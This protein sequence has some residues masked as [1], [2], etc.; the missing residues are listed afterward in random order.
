MPA[1]CEWKRVCICKERERDRE[2]ERERERERA[3]ERE[4]ESEGGREGGREG[5]REAGAHRS[6]CVEWR[7]RWFG[8][9]SL[10]QKF[11]P[12]GSSGNISKTIITILNMGTLYTRHDGKRLN[13]WELTWEPLRANVA[14]RMSMIMGCAGASCLFLF[15]ICKLKSLALVFTL[16]ILSACVCTNLHMYINSTHTH[17]H[18]CILSAS[19]CMCICIYVYREREREREAKISNIMLRYNT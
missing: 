2:R 8:R 11:L 16:Y 3:R 13:R 14:E 5:E 12:Q 4:R 19:I 18:T 10:D 9:A 7:D 6:G 15:P 1:L 17:A